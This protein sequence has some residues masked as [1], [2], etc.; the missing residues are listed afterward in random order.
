VSH[1]NKIRGTRYETDVVGFLR[2]HAPGL[3]VEDPEQIQRNGAIYGHHDRGDVGGVPSWVHQCKDV[4]TWR[5]TEWIREA[6]KQRVNAR[7]AWYAIWKKTRG[8]GV[9]HSVVIMDADQFVQI[10]MALARKDCDS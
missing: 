2:E 9:A 3:G 10:M 1:P 7:A 8:K 4:D 6:K 5:I